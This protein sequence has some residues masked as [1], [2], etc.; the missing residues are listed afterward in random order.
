L[1]SGITSNIISCIAIDRKNNKWMGSP[2][3]LILFNEGGVVSIENNRLKN[4]VNIQKL[5]DQKFDFIKRYFPL[6]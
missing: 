2:E 5:S 4:P 1:N 6:N 3:G